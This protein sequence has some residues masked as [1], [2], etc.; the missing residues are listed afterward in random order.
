MPCSREKSFLFSFS[1]TIKAELYMF[2]TE[3]V[4]RLILRKS[5]KIA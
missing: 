1:A 2:K 3:Q 4:E 5:L